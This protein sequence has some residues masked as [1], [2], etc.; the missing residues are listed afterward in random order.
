MRRRTAFTF[1]ELVLVMCTVAILMAIA[2]PNFLEARTRSAV[3]RSVNELGLLKM[4]VDAYRLEHKVYPLNAE[5][6]VDDGWDLRALTTPVAYLS[7]LPMDIFTHRDIRGT[8]TLEPV[9]PV[10]YRYYNAVQLNK[11]GL[12]CGDEVDVRF[13]GYVAGVLWG[14]G[15]T[16]LTPDDPDETLF[17]PEGAERMRFYDPTNGTRTPGDIYMAF[18]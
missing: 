18:P 8:H 3:S 15:P 16:H 2:V 7:R 11:E 12:V 1:V 17:G 5:P 9:R 6:G 4:A 14:Y 13:D 10:P